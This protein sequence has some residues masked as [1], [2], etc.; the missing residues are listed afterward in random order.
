M[1]QYNIFLS[2]IVCVVYWKDGVLLQLLYIQYLVSLKKNQHICLH[3]PWHVANYLW[4]PMPS[5]LS[6]IHQHN[7]RILLMVFSYKE[8]PFLHTNVMSTHRALSLKSNAKHMKKYVRHLSHKITTYQYQHQQT[9][10]F[11]D[12]HIFSTI[13]YYN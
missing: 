10:N 2:G 8:D 1:Y 9:I 5:Q 7:I 12:C 6:I 4:S 11:N 13:Q 3:S